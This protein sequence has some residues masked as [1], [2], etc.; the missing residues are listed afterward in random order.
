MLIPTIHVNGSSADALLTQL[1]DAQHALQGALE[2]LARAA[3]HGRD[4]YPQGDSAYRLAAEEHGA[5]ALKVR[6]VVHDLGVLREAICDQR[7]ARR[8]A[9]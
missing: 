7:R 6:E 9:R 4:Y 3:P 1:R 2:A 8:Q 5:R